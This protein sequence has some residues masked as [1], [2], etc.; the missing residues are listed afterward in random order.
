MEGFSFHFFLVLSLYFTQFQF[1]HFFL[2]QFNCTYLHWMVIL[3]DL[4]VIAWLTPCKRVSWR[5]HC[6]GNRKG[7][8]VAEGIRGGEIEI[9]FS[10]VKRNIFSEMGESGVKVPK[11]ELRCE[12]RWD[13]NFSIPFSYHLLSFRDTFHVR[14]SVNLKKCAKRQVF[15]GHFAWSSLRMSFLLPQNTAR[16]PWVW[17]WLNIGHNRHLLAQFSASSGTMNIF[18]KEARDRQKLSPNLADFL[19]SSWLKHQCL[20]GRK[21]I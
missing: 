18:A 6:W 1:N 8:N 16:C 21:I 10:R 3:V 14:E 12:N 11:D 7:K 2:P 9:Q 4:T 13:S 15:W 5:Q 20:Q 17:C 19:C